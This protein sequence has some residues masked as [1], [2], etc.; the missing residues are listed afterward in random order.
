MT[1][2]FSHVIYYVEDIEKSLLFFKKVFG[3]ETNFFHESGAYAE[4]STGATTL[5]FTSD[6]LAM[7][8]LPDGYKTN[9]NRELPLGCELVFTSKD[10]KGLYLK[11]LDHGA[12]DVLA[13]MHKPWGQIVA[14]VRDPNGI[15]LE[16]ASPMSEE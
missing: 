1:M 5:A 4:L 14:Y 12:K 16:I 13:P 8:N 7:S 10:I 2:T 9:S 6:S 15:L 11:A 3:L